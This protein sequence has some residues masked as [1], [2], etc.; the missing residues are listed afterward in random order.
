MEALAY[1]LEMQS[2]GVAPNTAI[3]NHCIWAAERG[4]QHQVSSSLFNPPSTA[5]TPNPT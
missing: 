2:V 4:G 1:L 5:Y 3:F